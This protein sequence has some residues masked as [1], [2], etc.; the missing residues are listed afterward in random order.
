MIYGPHLVR[1]CHL[2]GGGG[3]FHFCYVTRVSFVPSF[4]NYTHRSFLPLCTPLIVP[5]FLPRRLHRTF[6]HMKL[7]N[8]LLLY[9]Y[10]SPSSLPF[11]RSYPVRSF[12]FCQDGCPSSP[13]ST[14]FPLQMAQSGIIGPLPSRGSHSRQ[15]HTRLI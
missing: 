6:H 12:L 7:A 2:L 4:L 15:H 8:P 9:L 13:R 10:D 3:Y 14:R 1:A 11:T 5:S